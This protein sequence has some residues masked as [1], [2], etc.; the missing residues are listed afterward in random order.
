MS[1]DWVI[2][3]WFGLNRCEVLPEGRSQAV[4]DDAGH[5]WKQHTG[6]DSRLRG[7]D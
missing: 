4:L 2:L 1:F 6:L 5:C 7:S 3:P